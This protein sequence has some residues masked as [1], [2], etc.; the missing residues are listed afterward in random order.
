MTVNRGHLY[1]QTISWQW[2]LFVLAMILWV[3]SE[4]SWGMLGFNLDLNY[5]VL[6]G[7]ALTMVGVA[8]LFAQVRQAATASREAVQG[9]HAEFG[10]LSFM[11]PHNGAELAGF[12]VLSLTAGIVEET[13]WRG[14]LFWYLGQVMPI[15]AAAI[16]SA[17][18]FG[19][20]HSYQGLANVPRVVLAGAVFAGLYL[21][22]GSLWLPMILHAA[23][24]LLQGRLAYDVMRRVAYDNNS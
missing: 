12:N 1:A 16:I 3:I 18:G 24:D 11:I 23:V 10:K 22:T 2:G 20:A 14:F 17:A 9:L 21:L 15:W 6:I 13:L 5:R 19:L 7:T 4:R 8:V